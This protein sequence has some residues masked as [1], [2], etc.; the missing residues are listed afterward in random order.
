MHGHGTTPGYTGHVP[1]VKTHSLGATTH[2]SAQIGLDKPPL[3]PHGCW[4]L[5]P[6][7]L[8]LPSCLCDC[9]SP[10]GALRTSLSQCPSRMSRSGPSGLATA[11]AAR[12]TRRATTRR[13]SSRGRTRSSS[14]ASGVPSP[15]RALGRAQMRLSGWAS[16]VCSMNF[17][18]M[19]DCVRVRARP[20]RRRAAHVWY[21]SVARRRSGDG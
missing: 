10:G 17:G 18:V 9:L 19:C 1:R 5:P 4:L 21:L 20:E 15:R 6:L 8:P 7:P 3:P 2:S 13:R 14:R 11:T 12:T 16:G